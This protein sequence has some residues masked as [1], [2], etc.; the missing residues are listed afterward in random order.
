MKRLLAVFICIIALSASLSSCTK[1]YTCTFKDGK[2]QELCA[3]DFP[4][5]Y[6]GMKLTIKAYEK[7]GIKC[8]AK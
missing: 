8:D 5:G 7:Q 1:C 3:K 2:V 6:D 4:D